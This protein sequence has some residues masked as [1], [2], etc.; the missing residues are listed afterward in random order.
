MR[1]K[2]PPKTK[3]KLIKNPTEGESTNSEFPFF[4]LSWIQK[5]YQIS[6]CS[7]KDKV[8]FVNFLDSMSRM[9][10]GDIT[11]S[12][13]TGLGCEKISRLNKNIPDIA[14]GHAILSFRGAGI[15]RII[16]FR[17]GMAFYVLW[18]DTKGEVYSHG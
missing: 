12:S 1:V 15:M 13:R 14:A 10:W 2:Q 7:E 4:M 18:I 16:G 5:G 6:D 9:T 11:Q 17:S 8:K 3:S